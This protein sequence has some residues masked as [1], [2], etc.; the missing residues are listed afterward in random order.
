MS[1]QQKQS[2]S[3]FPHLAHEHMHLLMNCFSACCACAKMCIDEGHK[4]S[5]ILCNECADVCSL[6]IKFHSSDSEFNKQVLQLCAQVCKRCGEECSKMEAA[7]CKQCSVLCFECAE[8]C[9]KA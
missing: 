9:K 2:Y 4:K 6:A 3:A 1:N 8:A 5:A 7:H